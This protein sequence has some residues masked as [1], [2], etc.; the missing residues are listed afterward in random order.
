MNIFLNKTI[1]YIMNCFEKFIEKH[2]DKDWDWGIDGFSR[3]Q[4]TKEIKNERKQQILEILKEKT[5]NI[6]YDNNITNIII[7]YIN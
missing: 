2:I 6:N 7:N 5:K 1:H 4:F 3:N